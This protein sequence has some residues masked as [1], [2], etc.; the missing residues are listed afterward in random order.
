[1]YLHRSQKSLNKCFSKA[2][3]DGE[4][5]HYDNKKSF[6]YLLVLLF[7]NELDENGVSIVST[8]NHKAVLA[9]NST[10][11]QQGQRRGKGVKIK[12]IPAIITPLLVKRNQLS[13][14]ICR[15]AILC[16]FC[17]IIPLQLLGKTIRKCTDEFWP[18]RICDHQAA[19]STESFLSH[20]DW[21]RAIV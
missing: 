13:Q 4:I 11:L 3:L 7:F 12:P 16:Y 14:I 2:A 6:N 21:T 9:H 10:K 1:M 17:S 20:V 15:Q 5:C 19:I 18:S 8:A